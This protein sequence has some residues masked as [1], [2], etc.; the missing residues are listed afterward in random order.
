MHVYVTH[1]PTLLFIM[2]SMLLSGVGMCVC[3]KGSS[4]YV[5]SNKNKE[6]THYTHSH[7]YSAITYTA[8][9]ALINIYFSF[10]IFCCTKYSFIHLT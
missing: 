6:G 7:T 2:A 4:V 5:V 3:R 10:F 8:A 1:T 9:W